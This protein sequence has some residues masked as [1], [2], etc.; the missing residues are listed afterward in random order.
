MIG[1][2][3]ENISEFSEDYKKQ[4]GV[5]PIHRHQSEPRK[6]KASVIDEIILYAFDRVKKF[7][8]GIPRG[9]AKLVWEAI[10]D[11]VENDDFPRKDPRFFNCIYEINQES[12]EYFPYPGQSN[13]TKFLKRKDFD[14]KLSR[15][16]KRFT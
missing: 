3:P 11:C 7:N 8:S 14:S 15:L 9:I 4:F 5:Y 6:R 12:I 1:G 10:H 13:D 16:R 2:K